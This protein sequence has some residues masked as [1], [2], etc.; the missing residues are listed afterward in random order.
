M[1]DYSLLLLGSCQ[2]EALDARS[3]ASLKDDMTGSG[4]FPQQV[5]ASSFLARFLNMNL[6]LLSLFLIGW[7][8]DWSRL[9]K[10]G[11]E[12]YAAGD[13]DVALEAYQSAVE[14]RPKEAISHYNLGTALYQKKRYD[15]AAN[16]FRRSLDSKEPL[17][18]AQGYYNLGN[19][20]FQSG[21]LQGAIRSYK[22]ALRLN[23][24]DYDAK[25]NLELA[26]EKLAK[27]QSRQQNQSNHQNANSKDP[28]HQQQPLR[29]G[30]GAE[31]ASTAPQPDESTSKAGQ[32][33]IQQT[34]GMSKED[35]IRI[36]EAMND[37]EKDIQK[38]LLRKR[39]A[40]RQRSE[41]DW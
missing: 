30:I 20:Q 33:S 31:R 24:D 32:N 39:L 9:M 37:D 5:K 19:A 25:Y 6:I 38:K 7:I 13:Y 34:D 1:R 21:D 36:L 14:R 16:E 26:L 23:P 29:S 4:V 11:N 18:Q 35:A 12:R 28:E 15:E 3:F 17:L 10:R 2:K 8:G 40:R 41:K 22:S 27:G